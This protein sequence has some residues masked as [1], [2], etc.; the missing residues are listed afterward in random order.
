MRNRDLL[1]HHIGGML[2][3]SRIGFGGMTCECDVLFKWGILHEVQHVVCL[4]LGEITFL[5]PLL[6]ALVSVL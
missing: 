1:A 4:D 6:A 5:P 2:M 3:V